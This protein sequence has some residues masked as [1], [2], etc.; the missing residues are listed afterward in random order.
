MPSRTTTP[1][2]AAPVA[3]S[4]TVRAGAQGLARFVFVEETRP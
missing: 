2:V 1:A 3:A 4:D